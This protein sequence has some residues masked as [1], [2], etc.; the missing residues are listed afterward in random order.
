MRNTLVDAIRGILIFYVVFVTHGLFWLDFPSQLLASTIL[1]EMPAIF[2]VAG[3]SYCLWEG[4]KKRLQLYQTPSNRYFSFL[5][6]RV[7]KILLPYFVYAGTCA[8]IVI[9]QASTHGGIELLGLIASWLNP[10]VY[11]RAVSLG[12]LNWHLWFIPVFLLITVLLPLTT[13]FALGT[14]FS[15]W[16]IAIAFLV[17]QI[18]MEGINFPAERLLKQTLFYLIFTL[19][20]YRLAK[21]GKGISQ[22]QLALATLGSALLLVLSSIYVQELDVFDMQKNKFPP[23]Y[24]FFIFSVFWMSIFLFLGERYPSLTESITQLGNSLYLKPFRAAGYSIY[25][26]QGLAYTISMWIGNQI[27]APRLV[28]LLSALMLSVAFGL[29]SSFV[30]RIRLV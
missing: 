6:S 13:K 2:M 1:F 29:V 5:A 4:N 3:Y 18:A 7:S 26:W 21:L 10:F 30:E 23:N 11:G 14:N 25:L 19:A 22:K 27:E 17:F 9:S 24:L 28:I 20:G 12:A 8:T 16:T 15:V